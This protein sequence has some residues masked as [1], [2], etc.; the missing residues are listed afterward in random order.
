M[1]NLKRGLVVSAAVVGAGALGLVAG[2]LLAPASGVETRRRI[3]RRIEDEAE[4]LRR[5]GREAVEHFGERASE[6]LAEG[7]RKVGEL[8]HS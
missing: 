1:T 6:R 5:K 2:L 4:V 8:I 7:T 3:S